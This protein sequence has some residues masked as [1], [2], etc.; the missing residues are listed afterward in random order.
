MAQ[1]V[2]YLIWANGTR[3]SMLTASWMD[4]FLRPNNRSVH[5]WRKISKHI[6]V[7][8]THTPS[9]SLNWPLLTHQAQA[10]AHDRRLQSATIADG[11]LGR[12]ARK[13]PC[14]YS[15]MAR[16]LGW[17]VCAVFHSTGRAVQKKK[18][19][20][21]LRSHNPTCRAEKG[22]KKKTQEL[23]WQLNWG[24]NAHYHTRA[25]DRVGKRRWR[26]VVKLSHSAAATRA[27]LSFYERD[28]EIT[29]RGELWLLR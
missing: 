6:P 28:S 19:K 4:C 1:E 10:S 22:G 3:E 8:W 23:S 7:K 17:R 2:L 27:A 12:E 24:R 16:V 5:P 18:K 11:G 21:S 20:K 15:I 13:Y 29:L 26:N 14:T 9:L 25:R